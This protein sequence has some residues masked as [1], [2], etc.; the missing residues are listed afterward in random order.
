VSQIHFFSL[1]DAILFQG[2]G[3]FQTQNMQS[4][5]RSVKSQ[6]D[7]DRLRQLHMLDK[8]EEDKDMSWECCKLVEYHKQKGDDKSTNH[9]FLM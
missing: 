8:T 9:K 2:H 1:Y 7:F 4:D 5:Y 6:V 3:K